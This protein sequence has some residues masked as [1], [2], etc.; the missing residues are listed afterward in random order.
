M[1]QDNR[2]VRGIDF[3]GN[4]YE[5][6]GNAQFPNAYGPG[7]S[8]ETVYGGN[9]EMTLEQLRY[10]MGQGNMQGIPQ[11]VQAM[12][13]YQGTTGADGSLKSMYEYNP[14]DSAAFSRMSD[15]AM[16]RG[17]TDVYRDQAGVIDQNTNVYGNRL[18]SDAARTYGTGLSNLAQSGGL[19][20]GARERLQTSS[21]QNRL[22]AGSNLYAQSAG[23]KAQALA[24]DSAMK[25]KMLG[26]VADTENAASQ[27]NIGNMMGDLQNKNQANMY[28]WGKLGEIQG[29]QKI[30]D[31]MYDPNEE[32]SDFVNNIRSGRW[33]P[34]GIIPGTRGGT[35]DKDWVG[36]GVGTQARKIKNLVGG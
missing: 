11:L 15:I 9:G 24:S 13:Q 19:D 30:A 27:Y 34:L 12:P 8:S 22:N 32:D 20:S 5:I 23:D 29:S 33:S 25:M 35:G 18:D 2:P 28:Q 10:Q 4:P 31:Q 16:S 21:Q 36:T 26:G 3:S 7:P 6:P 1:A 17:P 14:S